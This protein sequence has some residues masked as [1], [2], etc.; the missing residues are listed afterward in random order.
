MAV[1]VLLAALTACSIGVSSG[2][3]PVPPTIQAVGVATDIR[4]YPDYTRIVFADGSVHEVPNSYRQVGESTGFW[5][6][7]IGSDAEGNFVASFP[8]QG[9]LPPDCYRENAAG[10][11]RGDYI[12]AEG[13]MWA[14]AP[15]FSAPVQ[16]AVGSKYPPGMRFCFDDRGLVSGVVVS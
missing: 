3:A 1:V 2:P 13:V 5:L 8:T 9:G 12:E 14:K 16:P 6:V 4:I 10:I 11:E 15:D 7:I